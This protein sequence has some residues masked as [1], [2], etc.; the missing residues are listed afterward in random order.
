MPIT[1]LRKINIWEFNMATF[2][3]NINK[4]KFLIFGKT[5]Q[6]VYFESEKEYKEKKENSLDDS[7][8]KT[9]FY[10]WF[11]EKENAANKE[12]SVAEIFGLE[13]ARQKDGRKITAL[14][15]T[16]PHDL[17]P[18]IEVD[19][20]GKI[21]P[22]QFE[23]DY[24]KNKYN[25]ENYDISNEIMESGTNYIC[26]KDKTTGKTIV[27]YF[28]SNIMSA[29]HDIALYD[30]F[31]NWKS[32]VVVGKDFKMIPSGNDEE[33]DNYKIKSISEFYPEE[34]KSIWKNY[35]DLN[36]IQMER[37]YIAGYIIQGIVY[38]K[39][40][41][42]K[43]VDNN[44]KS[45]RN[46]LVDGLIECLHNKNF[47]G[48]IKEPEKLQNLMAQIDKENIYEILVI[49][50]NKTGKSLYD[51]IKKGTNGWEI[52]GRKHELRDA[53]NQ[54]LNKMQEDYTYTLDSEARN[55]FY[56]YEASQLIKNPNNHEALS[57]LLFNNSLTPRDL[58]NIL[59]KYREL[60]EESNTN[61]SPNLFETIMQDEK[62][63]LNIRINRTLSLIEKCISTNNPTL[64][65]DI[66][67]VGYKIVM[68]YC[69]SGCEDIKDHMIVNKNNLNALCIDILRY[70]N[71]EEVTEPPEISKPNGEIDL[72]Q[73]QGKTGDCWLLAGCISIY[74]KDKGK[75]ILES[76]ID[77]NKETGDVV[78]TLKGVNKKYTITLE[79]IENAVYLSGGDGDIR[80]IEIAFNK[81]M[82]ENAN[83]ENSRNYVDING[84]STEF[85]YHILFGNSERIDKYDKDMNNKFN[86]P[87][88]FYELGSL[89]F[90]IETGKYLDYDK[91]LKGAMI[92]EDGNPVDFVTHHA[93]A[94][95][96]SDENYVYLINP[97]DSSKLLRITPE[98]LET[99]L[100]NIGVGWA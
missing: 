96:K 43:V 18:Y 16:N 88:K 62:T 8:K 78:V 41:P 25:S 67:D 56:E 28:N 74:K 71:R 20:E 47:W 89:G 24:I 100:I 85:I 29:S 45:I 35:N 17:T 99:L 30:N 92:D 34:K 10:N 27:E 37:T 82:H 22:E 50:K 14:Q 64:M 80:A 13:L 55:Y 75:E 72:E 5:P 49:Y 61:V 69:K 63:D 93:Y 83:E 90:D 4:L 54:H 26:V 58:D 76:L 32:S 48:R 39:G 51:D 95:V 66:T 19:D 23:L 70:I 44:E 1:K 77:V 11:K 40:Q 7:Y 33:N 73:A 91:D 86:D 98:K 3:Y 31:G 38:K 21:V 79:E 6:D 84:N 2:N 87:D 65:K 97:W 68:E 15:A 42:Y 9:I 36:E 12:K 46:F 53:C 81:Y 57:K 52:F 59:N 60:A 94:I